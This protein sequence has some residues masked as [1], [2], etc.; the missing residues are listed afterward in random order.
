MDALKGIGG[1]AA[2]GINQALGTNIGGVAAGAAAAPGQ[3]Q[4]TALQ[5]NTQVAQQQAKQ[6]ARTYAQIASRLGTNAGALQNEINRTVSQNLIPSI[7]DIA[8]LPGQVDPSQKATADQLV[9]TIETAI[10][11]LSNPS[12]AANAAQAEK[13]WLSLTTAAAQAQN[14]ARFSQGKA[15][16]APAPTAPAPTAP[17]TADVEI[18]NKGEL[19]YRGH[20][21]N[22]SDP[23]ARQAVTDFLLAQKHLAANR[24]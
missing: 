1:V 9:K 18:N 4:K 14:L 15:P 22:P 16:T 3:I 21:Y 17:A 19:L 7:R 11:T 10:A 8:R 2:Q 20:P 24:P 5:I 6:L 23:I 12:T 13:V